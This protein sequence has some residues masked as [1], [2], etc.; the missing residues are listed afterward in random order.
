MAGN[1]PALGI[2][3]SCVK[4]GNVVDMGGAVEARLEDRR[5]PL[6]LSLEVLGEVEERAL[7]NGLLTAYRLIPAADAPAPHAECVSEDARVWRLR[8]AGALDDG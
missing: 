5:Q 3:V 2:G 1:Q 8:P 6:D 7:G 4:G